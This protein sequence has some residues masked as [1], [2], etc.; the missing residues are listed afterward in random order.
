MHWELPHSAN[1]LKLSGTP[2]FA[3]FL[4]DT[5]GWTLWSFRSPLPTARMYCLINCGFKTS[6]PLLFVSAEYEWHFSLIFPLHNHDLIAFSSES[7]FA[8]FSDF[9]DGH[10]FYSD[11][12]CPQHWP[13]CTQAWWLVISVHVLWCHH[14][15]FLPPTHQFHSS[16]IPV[17][18]LHHYHYFHLTFIDSLSTSLSSTIW[19][20]SALVTCETKGPATALKYVGQPESKDIN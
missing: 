16:F 13:H 4:S 10:V 9:T 19:L 8:D 18:N 6:V 14:T 11:S 20:T 5:Y 7:P 1:S 15:W 2:L 3:H 12:V 17:H